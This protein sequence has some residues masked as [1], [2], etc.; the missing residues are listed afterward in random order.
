MTVRDIS[1]ILNVHES[2]P[3]AILCT[4]NWAASH[5]G[6]P[7]AILI[8]QM[9]ANRIYRPFSAHFIWAASLWGQSVP[10]PGI[11]MC[12]NR[13]YRPLSAHFI[14][15]AHIWAQ[16]PNIDHLMLTRRVTPKADSLSTCRG[17][18]NR[19]ALRAVQDTSSSIPA[20]LCWHAEWPLR[21]IRCQLA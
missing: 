4:F 9:C 5:R 12:T 2:L 14:W 19:N 3:Q 10:I 13:I 8:I 20:T 11:Q 21:P 7:I 17:S 6:L 18:K 15:A 16:I 1:H